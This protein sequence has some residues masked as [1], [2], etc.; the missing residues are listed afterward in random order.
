MNPVYQDCLLKSAICNKRK[1]IYEWKT[2]QAMLKTSKKIPSAALNQTDL[3][4]SFIFS[5]RALIDRYCSVEGGKVTNTHTSF[6][7]ASKPTITIKKSQTTN[8]L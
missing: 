3:F 2:P 4:A 1:N 5:K 7:L 6:T 8:A